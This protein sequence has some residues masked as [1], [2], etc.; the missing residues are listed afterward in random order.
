MRTSQEAWESGGGGKYERRP[1]KGE[2]AKEFARSMMRKNPNAYFYR[3][4]L[5][6]A[7]GCRARPA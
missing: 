5:T 1:P 2:S 3:C 6:G 7:R 4:G